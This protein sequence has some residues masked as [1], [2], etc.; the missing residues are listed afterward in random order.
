MIK[1]FSK[2]KVLTKHPHPYESPDYHTPAGSIEDNNSFSYFIHEIDKYFNL[3]PYR[4]LDIGC[5][6]GQFVIDIY[7]KG[8]PWK[9]IG[10]DGGNKYGMS[11]QFDE[12]IETG[13]GELTKA[14]G[15]E[16][17]QR[18]KDVCLFN[19]DV[20][21]PFVALNEDG[22][23]MTFDIVTAW[24]FFEH[25]KPEDIPQILKNVTN[26]MQKGS[27]MLGTI[28]ISPGEHHQCCKSAEWWNDLF[29]KHNFEVKEY[30]FLT[31]PRTDNYYF[32]LIPLA[33]KQGVL[34]LC[35]TVHKN[36]EN[37]PFFIQYKGD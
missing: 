16:N 14:R 33:R 7:N 22:R 3:Y 35:E 15:F 34:P 28:N 6:G 11:K 5:A 32:S 27:I 29:E 26:H 9:A 19:A 18:Y 23:K 1:Q 12:P 21:K 13:T 24:E 17:W 31:S 4:L 20:T 10:I 30:P 25:P 2:F 37:Y 8:E 36:I